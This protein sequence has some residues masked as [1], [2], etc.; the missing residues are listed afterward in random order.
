MAITGEL[1]RERPGELA[2]AMGDACECEEF[3]PA[4]KE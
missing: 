3:E 4:L 2:T 1:A